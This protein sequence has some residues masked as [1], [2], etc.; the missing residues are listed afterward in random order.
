MQHNH[1]QPTSVNEQ[2]LIHFPFLGRNLIM[3]QCLNL[4]ISVL[5]CKSVDLHC[6]HVTSF[7]WT[8][9]GLNTQHAEGQNMLN[10][11]SLWHNT[12][13]GSR[14]I[15]YLVT[16]V[17]YQLYDNFILLVN[18]I[19]ELLQELI[20]CLQFIFI[21]QHLYEFLEEKS[22]GVGSDEQGGWPCGF[23]WPN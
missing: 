8:E 15:I 14:K 12:N 3:D 9:L 22:K 4:T 7:E 10:L 18:H 11:V 2:L 17:S 20:S 16:L 1:T 23:P 13:M 21:N 19:H 6:S 5:T